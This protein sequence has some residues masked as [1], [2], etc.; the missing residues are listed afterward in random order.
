MREAFHDQLEHITDKLVGMTFK[1][2]EQMKSATAALLEADIH[3]ADMTIAGDASINRDQLEIDEQV[4]ELIATQAPVA[5]DLREV[6]SALRSTT[7][8]ERMG[9]LA[10]HVAKVARMRYPDSAVP[11]EF[12]ETFAEMGRV[13]EAMA[14]KAG[15]VLR[16][17]DLAVADELESD[18]D[19]MDRLHRSL[20][21]VL[22]DTD[23]KSSVEVPIDIA[24]LGRYYER[25]ADHAVHVAVNVRYLITGEVEWAGKAPN[26]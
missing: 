21:L 24:L 10:V 17:R 5:G 7:T 18:D 23:W 11:E 8:L 20:F 13:A 2:G 4:L 6:M 9:D 3:R 25:F 14:N 16:T 1:C 22:L 15:Q 19:Q 26:H 12:R